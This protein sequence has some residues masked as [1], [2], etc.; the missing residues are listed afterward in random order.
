MTEMAQLECKVDEALRLL[1]SLVEEPKPHL[2]RVE[3]AEKAGI[4]TKTVTR[5]ITAGLI[6]T[7]K[8]GIPQSELRKFTS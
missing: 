5:K 3:F 2:T 6:R 7:E 1:R 4:S 8:G